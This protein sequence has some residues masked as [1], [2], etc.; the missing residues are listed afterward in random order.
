MAKLVKWPLPVQNM[1]CY[2]HNFHFVDVV[3]IISDHSTKH[4]TWHLSPCI[5]AS[6]CHFVGEGGISMMLDFLIYVKTILQLW[7]TTVTFCVL[8][9]DGLDVTVAEHV[10]SSIN[11]IILLNL[12]GDMLFIK[13]C[14]E[15]R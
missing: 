5:I 10:N 4:K 7:D 6:Y 8:F 2:H 3:E 1:Q 15:L 14:I 12:L 11:I 13:L 9:V